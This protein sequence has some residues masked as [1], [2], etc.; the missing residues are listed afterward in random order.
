MKKSNFFKLTAFVAA[1]ALLLIGGMPVAQQVAWAESATV[2][3]TDIH[4]T[5]SVPVN[6]QNVVALDN[7]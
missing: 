1:F 6:P 4:G 5:V 3:V 7:K 2:E